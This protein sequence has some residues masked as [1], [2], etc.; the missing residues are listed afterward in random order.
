MKVLN[1]R[2]GHGHGF[3]GWFGSEAEFQDQLARSLVECPVCGDGQIE[4]LPA[5][6][7]LNLGASEA[8]PVGKA[9]QTPVDLA[10]QAKAWARL[11]EAMARAEDVG[12]RFVD[13]ARRM[14]QGEIEERHIRGRA[15]LGDAL[16]LL[17]EGVPVLPLPPALKETLQ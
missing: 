1:L 2:C 5:A 11:R 10:A 15:S 12:E 17:Q 13:E 14:H 16:E 4:K 3:E 9:P 6:P 8:A 7:R